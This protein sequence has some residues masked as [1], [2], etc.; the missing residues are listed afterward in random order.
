MGPKGNT[1]Y[2]KTKG[3]MGDCGAL[4]NAGFMLRVSTGID[5]ESYPDESREISDFQAWGHYTVTSF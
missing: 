5:R 4:D 1:Q 2:T 3:V